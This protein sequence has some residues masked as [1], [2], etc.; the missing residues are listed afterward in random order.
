MRITIVGSGYV[1]LVSGACFAAWGHQVICVDNDARKIA[2][3]RQ[4]IIPIYEP[5]L[6]SLVRQGIKAATLS[7]TTDCAAAVDGSSVVMIAV[8][9]PPRPRDGNADL[10]FLYGAVKEVATALTGYAVIVTKSTVP[11]GTG[12]EIARIV[13]RTRPDAEFSVASNPE[14]LREG[15]AVGDFLQP[16]RIVVG[17]M[18]AP[19]FAMLDR[20]YAPLIGAGIAVVKTERRTAELI[21]YAANAFLAVKISFINEVA[22]LCE[23]VDAD[24]EKVSLGIGL[25]RRIGASFLKAGPG[26]GGSCFPKDTLALLRTSQDYGVPLRLVEETVAV[27]DARKRRMALKVID[28]L[29]GSVDGEV[30]AILGLAFKADTDDVRETPAFPLIEALQRAGARIRAFDP[31]AMERSR[32]ILDEVTFCTDPYQCADGA[33]AIVLVTDWPEFRDLEFPRLAK[34]MRRRTLIDLRNAVDADAAGVSGFTVTS[35]GRPTAAQP[36]GRKAN[37]TQE[38]GSDIGAIYAKPEN[39]Q[40][41]HGVM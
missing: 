14:F 27:N 8:G 29:G 39:P 36:H 13:S 7:F 37:Q 23:R 5:G 32:A 6:E 33:S 18:D 15:S 9:T 20:L 2:D 1:G 30:I 3:L 24:I 12:D 26:F 10:S 41:R 21:K 34:I 31:Q 35:I 25:D 28:A 38:E 17:A 11:V 19:A 4:G 40:H 16:D 22:D